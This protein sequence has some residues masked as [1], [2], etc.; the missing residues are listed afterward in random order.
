MTKNFDNINIDELLESRHLIALIWSTEDVLIVRPDLSEEQA[1]QVLQKVDRDHDSV[2]Q[3]N[4]ETIEWYAD[5]MF[6]GKE[7]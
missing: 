7:E 3:I 1:W 6:P 4:W 5:A 2:S